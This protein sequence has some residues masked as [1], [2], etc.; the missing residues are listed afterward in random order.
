MSNGDWEIEPILGQRISR[1]VEE[2]PDEARKAAQDN[3][4]LKKFFKKY[5]EDEILEALSKSPDASEIIREF[6]LRS[7]NRR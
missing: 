7:P 1:V 3:V 5:N 4:K 6:I 2:H